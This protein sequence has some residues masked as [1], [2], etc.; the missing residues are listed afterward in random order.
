MRRTHNPKFVPIIR[1]GAS[2]EIREM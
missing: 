1:T 2:G